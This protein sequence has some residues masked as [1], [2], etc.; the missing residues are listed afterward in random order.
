MRGQVILVDHQPHPTGGGAA[1]TDFTTDSGQEHYWQLVADD[2]T[3]SS[4]AATQHA[5]WWGLYGGTFSGSWDPP[6]GS[7]TMRLRFYSARAGDGLPG[8]IVYEENFVDP[9]RVWTGRY[10]TG[11]PE[12]RFE[13]DLALPFQVASD[14]TYWLELVQVGISESHFRW[15]FSQPGD[16]TSF[17]FL[18][19][20]VPDWTSAGLSSNCAFQ[21]WAVPEPGSSMILG[22]GFATMF[23]FRPGEERRARRTHHA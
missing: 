5:V 4:S 9:S 12:Y 8:D 2:F 18:N 6:P 15:E 10:I 22:T 23:V 14:T 3:L 1:D 20:A 13:A 17:V 11:H 7:E 19:P 21:L 16:G